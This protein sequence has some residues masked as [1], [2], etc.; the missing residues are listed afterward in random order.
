MNRT[1]KIIIGIAVLC[2]A[3]VL[4]ALD[5]DETGWFRADHPSLYAV[6]GDRNTYSTPNDGFDYVELSLSLKEPELLTSLMIEADI[7]GRVLFG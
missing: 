5:V 3:L 1:S 4:G 7:L 2:Q 6:D